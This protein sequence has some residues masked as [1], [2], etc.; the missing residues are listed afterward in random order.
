MNKEIIRVKRVIKFCLLATFLLAT[1]VAAQAQSGAICGFPR[2]CVPAYKFKPYELPF[3]TGRQ[4][5]F[6]PGDYVESDYFY[7][8]VLGTINTSDTSEGDDFFFNETKRLAA[9]KLFPNNKVFASRCCGDG[10]AL[11][12]EGLPDSYNFLAVHGGENEEDATKLLSI[13]KRK[14]PSAEIKKMRVVLDFRPGKAK[15]N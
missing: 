8:V 1:A 2:N 6:K 5:K 11:H 13:A 15:S 4:A 10:G 9:Q 14:Y 12:Y 7:A 3:S